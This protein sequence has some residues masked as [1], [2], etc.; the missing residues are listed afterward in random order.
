LQRAF[1]VVSNKETGKDKV[2]VCNISNSE[3][4]KETRKGI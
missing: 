2:K 1:Y 4:R 3:S